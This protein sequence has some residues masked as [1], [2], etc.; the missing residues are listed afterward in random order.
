MPWQNTL[1][2]AHT[3]L[4]CLSQVLNAHH[5]LTLEGTVMARALLCSTAGI[6]GRGWCPGAP[7]QHDAAAGQTTERRGKGTK[8]QNERS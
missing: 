6:W 4:D 3:L 1:Q 5:G 7:F 2:L 8:G